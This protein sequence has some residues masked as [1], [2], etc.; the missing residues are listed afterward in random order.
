MKTSIERTYLHVPY[1]DSKTVKALGAR[2]DTE[3][4]QWYVKPGFLISPFARWLSAPVHTAPVPV[5]TQVIPYQ[6]PRFK[7]TWGK[8]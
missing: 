3:R 4:R 8:R 6:E 5:A 7:T 2:F 1:A